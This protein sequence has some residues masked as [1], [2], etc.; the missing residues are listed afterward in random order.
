MS[1]KIPTKFLLNKEYQVSWKMYSVSAKQ[2]SIT[3]ILVRVNGKFSKPESNLGTLDFSIRAPC[4][5]LTENS[6]ELSQDESDYW[7]FY[8]LDG[9]L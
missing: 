7:S 8:P 2:L 5:W 1:F 3:E 4:Y 6:R 9:G